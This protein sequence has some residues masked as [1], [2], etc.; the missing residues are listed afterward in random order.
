MAEF[1]VRLEDWAQRTFSAE[2][3]RWAGLFVISG[4]RSPL[5]QAEV[6]P[7]APASL[8]TRCPSLAADLRVGDVPASLTT[9]ETWAFLASYWFTLGG[10]WGGRFTPPD[11]NHFDLPSLSITG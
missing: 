8:H 11:N 2:G 4:F 7:L 5:L 3:L 9:V 1:L 6:N 10:R